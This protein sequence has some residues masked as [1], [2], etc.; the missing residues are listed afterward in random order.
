M[1]FP[2]HSSTRVSKNWAALTGADRP[3]Q[4]IGD[5]SSVNQVAVGASQRVADTTVQVSNA[6]ERSSAGAG[7]ITQDSRVAVAVSDEGHVVV[8]EVGNQEGRPV[9]RRGLLL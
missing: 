7:L 3:R 5:D 1:R 9:G 2:C 6:P 4:Y 8:I